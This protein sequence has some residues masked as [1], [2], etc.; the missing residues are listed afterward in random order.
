MKKIKCRGTT[1]KVSGVQKKDKT[2]FIEEVRI[3]I[4]VKTLMILFSRKLENLKIRRKNFENKFRDSI[5]LYRKTIKC[6]VPFQTKKKSR[7]RD[8]IEL[9]I[10]YFISFQFQANLYLKLSDFHNSKIQMKYYKL[11]SDRYFLVKCD[12]R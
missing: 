1:T 11:I 7:A 12:I 10:Q 8:N 2:Q 5:W 3:L 4:L 6:K 9:R